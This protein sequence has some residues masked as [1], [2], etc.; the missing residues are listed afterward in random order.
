MPK[1]TAV[2]ETFVTPE[3]FKE[4]I[5]DFESYPEFMKEVKRV[6]IHERS[7]TA[8]DA[9]FHIDIGFMGVE[10]KSHYRVRYAIEDLVIRWE[11]VESPTI[12]QNAGSWTLERTDDDECIGRYEVELATNLG[13]P[14][15]IEAAFSEQELPKMME[16]LRDRVEG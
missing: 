5:L 15:E 16:K 2:V 14:P 8:I 11:L 4:Q 10:I 1:A 12:T 13:I 9:T 7:D 6:E 3:E